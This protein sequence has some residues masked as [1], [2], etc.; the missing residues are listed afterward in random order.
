MAENSFFSNSSD[1][2]ADKKEEFETAHEMFSELRGKC[3][4]AHSN[5]YDGFWAL[6]KYGDVVNVLKNPS[7]YIT[8]VQNVVPKVSTTG[9]R[10]PLHLDPPEHSPY[11]RT[12]DPF[13]KK[14]KMEQIEPDVRKI[15]VDLLH[16][17]IKKNGGDIC[18]EFSHL[19][20]GHVFAEFFN[21]T[22]E[23]SMSIREVTQKYVKALHVMDKENIQKYSIELYDIARAIIDMRKKEP[24]DPEH[25]VVSAYL[26]RKY[27]GKPLPENMILGTIR[28]LIVVGMI[29]PVVFVGSMSVHLSQNPQLQGKLRQ[30]LDLVPD[31]I[32]E[33]LR[34]FTPYRG[35]ARTPNED[36]EIGDRHIKKDEPIALVFASAN[37][38]E[39]VFPNGDE[40]ILN[41]ENIKD[42]VAFGLGPHRCPGAPL[43]RMMLQLTLKELL[44]RT[45]SIQLNGD[46]EMTRW[47]EYGAVSVP[48]KVY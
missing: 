47:P 39:D 32:E 9:R 12:L 30:N 42:H 34:L 31:A 4:V 5:S 25:D 20:P 17:F 26:A 36:V 23:L 35:F 6:L 29:A 18:S 10:P 43:A 24:L 19:L 40:F 13:F 8:S 28:Q 46:I 22:K 1:F 16:P 27:D 38:D 3:P 14:E 15:V 44:A 48:L 41:R 11:R 21:L 7:T 33:Y 2:V 37:R 45:E